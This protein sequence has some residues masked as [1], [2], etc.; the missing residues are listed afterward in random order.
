MPLTLGEAAAA[1]GIDKSTVR[2]ASRRTLRRR[3]FTP[4][5]TPQQTPKV[6]ELRAVIA[7]S[8]AKALELGFAAVVNAELA[9]VL[10]IGE[11]RQ[12]VRQP[13]VGAMRNNEPLAP[14]AD[15][16][17]RR[18]ADVG[19]GN[20]GIRKRPRKIQSDNKNSR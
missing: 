1:C 16:G 13:G 18:L 5:L 7:D 14:L 2:R 8:E 3:R 12:E 11:D 15:D 17:E 10:A 20:R 6:N 9:R 4:Y 19:Q